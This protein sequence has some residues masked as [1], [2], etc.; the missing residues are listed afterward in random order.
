MTKYTIAQLKEMLE[1]KLSHNFGVTINMKLNYT[2]KEGE[3]KCQYRNQP[4]NRKT[5]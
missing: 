4:M 5:T 2:I 1:K 3:A